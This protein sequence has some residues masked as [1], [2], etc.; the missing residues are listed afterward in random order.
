MDACMSGV[1]EVALIGRLRNLQCSHGHAIRMMAVCHDLRRM[2]RFRVLC[3]AR[4]LANDC[5]CPDCR[6][7]DYSPAVELKSRAYFDLFQAR[8]GI[9]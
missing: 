8:L 3:F 5:G 7:G 2:P 1:V 6:R 4:L 9:S